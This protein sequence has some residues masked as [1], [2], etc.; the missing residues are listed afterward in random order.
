MTEMQTR[1]RLLHPKRVVLQVSEGH[2]LQGARVG[3]LEDDRGRNPRIGRLAPSAGTEA[4]MVTG[5]EPGEPKIG[6]GRDE[7]VSAFKGELQEGLGHDGA[8]GMPTEVLRTGV[9]AP[10][11][12]ESSQWIE[13]TW[14]QRSP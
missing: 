12:E 14:L 13:A 6:P 4:P 7:I 9:T 11:P 5:L 8:N 3:C 2:H 10:I 1:L